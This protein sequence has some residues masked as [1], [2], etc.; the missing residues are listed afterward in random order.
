MREEKMEDRSRHIIPFEK[1]EDDLSPVYYQ[2]AKAIQI[3]IENGELAVGAQIP[4]EREFAAR[5]NVSLATV[6]KAL[7]NLVHQGLL[8]RIQGKG[9]F[10]S[11]T[12]SRRH[13][14]RYYPFV[15][16]FQQDAYV[17]DVQFLDLKKVKGQ[18][19]I[20]RYLQIE[21]S[22]ELYKMRRILLCRKNIPM[23]YSISY[24]PGHM[25]R[26]L[27]DYDH[28]RFEKYLYLFLE[29]EFGVSTIENEELYSAA[30]ADAETARHLQVEENHPL[31]RVDMIAF[32]HK[33]K[34]YEYRTSYCLT[35]EMKIRRVI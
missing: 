5:H 3:R 28:Q 30:L 24:L 8:S 21:A 27:P 31:L 33:K 13:K 1:S 10:V 14:L 32:T 16:D 35:D 23:V 34:P 22:V 25:F 17:I 26:G 19:R 15:K 4:S 6:R 20:N 29:D 9:T 12:D 11:D 2:L 18:E 7:E